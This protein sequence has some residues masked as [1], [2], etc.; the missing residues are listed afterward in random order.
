MTTIT[1]DLIKEL[2]D[3]TG[4]SVMQCKKALEETD[5]NMEEALMVLR[6]V[7]GEMA[8]KKADRTAADGAIAIAETSGKA[9]LIVLHS[10]TD[11]VA[12]NADFLALATKLAD[13]ALADGA[14]KTKEE[15]AALAHELV[16][17]IGENIQMGDIHIAEGAIVGT[18]LHHNK[19]AGALVALSG[20]TPELAKDIAMHIAAMNPEYTTA[21]DIPSDAR[22]KVVAFFEKETAESDKPADIKAK[23]LEGKVQGYLKEKTLLDQ[24]FFKNPDITVGKALEQSGASVISFVRVKIS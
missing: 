18:Y 5:G 4:V 11:F 2:R 22:E 17:K 15:G 6:K 24:P 8:A 23:M 9:A 14:D 16:L 13:M 3:K 12:Q 1:T 7:S 20:G 19:K 21:N 10:E